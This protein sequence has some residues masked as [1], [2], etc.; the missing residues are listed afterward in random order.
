MNLNRNAKAPAVPFPSPLQRA[1]IP[2]LNRCGLSLE[3]TVLTLEVL[4]RRGA[5]KAFCQSMLAHYDKTGSL[6]EHDQVMEMLAS[7]A[8]G[9]L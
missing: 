5:E 3:T 4:K 9:G 2:L 6:P 8:T 1:L 7:T